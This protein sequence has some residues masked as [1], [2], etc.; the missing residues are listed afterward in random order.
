MRWAHDVSD[1]STSRSEPQ[2][3]EIGSQMWN[4]LKHAHGLDPSYMAGRTADWASGEHRGRHKLSASD[5][6]PIRT[7]PVVRE[8]RWPWSRR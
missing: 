5:P 7:E 1:M 3:L 4:H 8:I 2:L 6:G